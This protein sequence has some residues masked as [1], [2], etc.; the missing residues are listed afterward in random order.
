VLFVGVCLGVTF[1]TCWVPP[2][3][4]PRYFA[5]LFPCVAVLI[6]LAVQSA[7]AA[8]PSSAVRAAWR[9]FL[10]L[11]AGAMVVTAVAVL[12][13]AAIGPSRP[14]LAPFAE[15]PL[16][17]L[18]FAF[19][20]VGMA[21]LTLRARIGADVSG[22]RTA[23][24]ALAGFLMLTFIGVGTDVRLRKSENA[25]EA[26]RQLKEKLPPRQPLVSINGFRGHTDSLFAYLY[27]TPFITPRPGFADE[28]ASEEGTYFCFISLGASRPPLPFVW[29]EVGVVSLD[30]NHH[31]VPERAVVVGRRPPAGPSSLNLV[32]ARAFGMAH[33]SP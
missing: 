1:P 26:M 25:A 20:A 7:A 14:L 18:G 15:P 27:G 5:P 28:P 16:V 22:A 23:V 30:R 19:A 32:P 12:G 8:P 9:R 31:P 4:L 6:G 3:G 21:Y 33:G 2:G 13:V 24:L 29:E 17:A 10:G 11:A